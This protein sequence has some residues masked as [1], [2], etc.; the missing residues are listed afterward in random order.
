MRTLTIHM[1]IPDRGGGRRAARARAMPTTTAEPRPS[2]G[3]DGSVRTLLRFG[4]CVVPF[5]PLYVSMSLLFPY[6]SGRNF[7]FRILTEILLLPLA[8]LI[9]LTGKPQRW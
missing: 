6:V 4:V 9:G 8:A 5:L 1:G 7:A 2:H 3:T